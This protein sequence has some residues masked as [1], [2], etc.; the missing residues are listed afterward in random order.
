MALYYL[1][2]IITGDLLKNFTSLST[3]TVVVVTKSISSLPR[4]ICLYHFLLQMKALF[5]VF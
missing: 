3:P 1:Q 5:N 4:D 2:V